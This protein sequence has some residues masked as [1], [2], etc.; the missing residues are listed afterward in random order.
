M[1]MSRFADLDGRWVA[2]E[3]PATS[4]NLGAGYDCLAVAL[5]IVDRVE[6]EAVARPG[7]GVELAVDGEGAGELPGDR[8]NALRRRPRARPRR[9]PRRVGGGARLADPDAQPD[10]PCPRPRLVGRGHRGRP[11]GRRGAGR[12]DPAGRSRPRP[13][14]GDRGPPRQRRRRPPRR[15]HDRR[16]RRRPPRD[17]VRRPARPPGDPLHPRP[18]PGHQRDAGRA[19]RDGPPRGRRG[20]PAAGRAGRGGA[21]RRQRRG[22]RRT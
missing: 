13:G 1:A 11:A 16:P 22:P 4:A 10:P 20:E 2:V 7:A 17:P 6:V 19:P 18:P 21:R 15:L 8:T 12:R 5:E 9:G 3:V 14:D